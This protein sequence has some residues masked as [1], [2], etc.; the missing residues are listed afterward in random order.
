MKQITIL[1]VDDTPGNLIVLEALLEEHNQTLNI[2][3]AEDGEEALK[4]LYKQ[5]VD[6][7]I[8][9]V[10]MPKL[11][12]F[13]TAKIMRNNPKTK[14]IPIIFL[15]AVF[16]AEEFIQYGFEL[17][18][19]DY[20][21]KPINEKQLMNRVNLYIRLFKEKK[22]LEIMNDELKQV[23]FND[24]LTGLPS[25]SSLLTDIDKYNNIM[26]LLVNINGF[27][28]INE[29]YGNKN[30]DILIVEFSKYLKEFAFKYGYKLFSLEGDKF[31]FSEFS[32]FFDKEKYEMLAE[33]LIE[34]ISKFEIY[35]EGT[36]V[37]VDST[38]SIAFGKEN[39]LECAD[40][41]YRYAKHHN[42]KYSVYSSSI[43]STIES[44][45]TLMWIQNVRNAIAND[46][47]IPVF[48]GIIDCKGDIIKYEALMR[49]DDDGVLITPYKFLD[50]A[51]KANLY[52]KLSSIMFYKVIGMMQKSDKDFSVNFTY[53][54]ILND[55][56]LDECETLIEQSG[57]G[58]R[59]IIEITENE[60]LSDLNRL[61]KFI[62]RFKKYGAR[63]AID[64]FGSG[65]SNFKHILDIEPNFL[66]LD[67][68]LVEDVEKNKKVRHFIEG[69]IGFL[70]E[71]NVTVIAEFVDSEVKYN[72]LKD[73]GVNEFQGYYFHKPSLWE[74]LE[75]R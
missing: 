47:I 19:I 70:K 12:G 46:K 63:I 20:M 3:T 17:G 54:D 64:D 53:S 59:L 51:K 9:D 38:L 45:N 74:D 18:A 36:L 62:N 68:T 16:K 37:H 30:G 23:T 28:F 29:V 56:Y 6:L 41:A 33:D 72:I 71:L 7:V 58:D 13:E 73:L 22:E 1:L 44:K 66:K 40:I 32:N 2:L 49:L 61:K 39:I 31:V 4:I 10:K 5:R 25:R 35:L 69:I 48:Q 75:I 52:P 55:T 15:T 8:L 21:T 57:V 42:E 26:I 27:R 65:Y 50:I 67:G 43:D 11:N 34:Y 14:E 24:K 60:N